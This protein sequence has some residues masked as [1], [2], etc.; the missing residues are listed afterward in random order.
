MVSV[1]LLTNPLISTVT[2]KLATYAIT[3]VLYEEK[4]P[5][6][7]ERYRSLFEDI[8]RIRTVRIELGLDRNVYGNY[9]CTLAFPF[10]KML[11]CKSCGADTAAT[12]AKYKFRN[13]KFWLDCKK[14]SNSGEAQARDIPVKTIQKIRV[15]R[16]NPKTIT[17]R[18]NDLTGVTEYFYTMTAALRNDITLGK[19]VAVE[20]TP[21]AFID[22]VAQKKTIK[23]DHTK[24]FHGKRPSASRDPSDNGWG[25]PLIMPVLKDLWFLQILRKSQEA[26]SLEH[27][28]PMRWVSPQVTVD[29][30]NVY[31]QINL[32]D[33]KKEVEQQIKQWK[34]DAN[35]IA[36]TGVPISPQTMGGQ[37]K[38]MLMHQE[39]R[40]YSEQIIAG[41]GVPTGFVYGEAMYSGAS[42]NMRALENEFMGANQDDLRLLEF[43]R[44][45]VCAFIGDD[46]P[47]IKLSL[48]PFKM[49][50]DIQRMQFDMQLAQA[51]FISHSTFLGKMD[52]DFETELDNITEE[53]KKIQKMQKEQMLA[54]AKAQG[55]AMLVTSGYQ[56][57]AQAQQAQVQAQI[58]AETGP[59]PMPELPGPPMPPEA[60]AQDGA[61]QGGA[62]QG[63]VAQAPAL[64]T[65]QA[66][67]MID[68]FAEAKRLVSQL[69]AMDD[70]TRYQNLARLR[71][72][73]PDLYM[74]VNQQLGG[75]GAKAPAPPPE[76]KPSR[77]AP[78]RAQI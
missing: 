62:M 51:Q 7:V 70:P 39:I 37:G 17:I 63:G 19:P 75:T 26:V 25:A 56:V 64:N 53:N 60:G 35:H 46:L 43:I 61:M 16:W 22:A 2:Q 5:G 12:D 48:K 33:W 68:L 74:L 69:R 28:L 4:H 66:G 58:T 41:M 23:L 20:T 44:D 21:Q 15:I 57:A 6:I 67:G 9:F 31:G 73:S 29:G 36:V 54:Q 47:K 65:P 59:P 1:L 52:Y 76:Q 50:D 34:Q 11:R 72:S 38:Q 10:K 30:N 14:C 55:E 13:Y 78:D 71:N 3:D 27:I 45:Q 42:V 24:L 77:A 40:I 32:Q 8:L 18:H 49:A